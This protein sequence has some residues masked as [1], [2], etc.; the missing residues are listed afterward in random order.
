MDM[1]IQ[2]AVKKLEKSGFTVRDTSSVT[3][4]AVRNGTAIDMHVSREG[5]ASCFR[6]RDIEEMDDVM[7]DYSAGVFCDNLSQAIRLAA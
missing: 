1:L 7:T 2:N 4:Q 5:K 3:K 6:V